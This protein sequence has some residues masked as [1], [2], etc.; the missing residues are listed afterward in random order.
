MTVKPKFYIT[1]PIYYVNA[2]PHLGH[3]YTSVAVDAMARHKRLSGY[4]V[5]FLT[6]VDEHGQKVETAA[7]EAGETPQAYV[8][9]ISVPF[10]EMTPALN[11]TNNDFIRTT[12]DRHQKTVQHLFNVL[13][14]K[15]YI[16]KGSYEGWYCVPDE[17]FFPETQLG[18][19]QTCPQCG[20]PVQKMEEETYFF[21]LSEF[22]DWFLKYVEEHPNTFL[23]EPRKNEVVQFVNQGLK[24]LSITRTSIHWGIPVPE[25]P[26]HVFYVWFDALINYLSAL[27]YGKDETLF[28]Q[29]WQDPQTEVIHVVGKEIFRF[30]SIIWFAML[31]A[32]GIR[33]PD[34]VVG[35][36]WWTVEGKKMSKSVG[37]VVNPF[38]VSKQYGAD[39]YRYFVLRELPFGTDGDYSEQALINRFD[40]DL[41]NDLGNLLY[42]TL[43]MLE[44]YNAG[45]IPDKPESGPELPLAEIIEKTKN[46]YNQLAFQQALINIWDPI[47]AA[48]KYIDQSAPWTHFKEGNSQRVG[49]ILYNVLETL[50]TVAVLLYPVMPSTSEKISYQLGIDDSITEKGYDSIQSWG[51]LP[52]GKPSR[53]GDPLFPRIQTK[54]DDP[55]GKK[56]K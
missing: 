8:D 45:V 41:A 53:K 10:R 7:Q 28:N 50:R 27:D 26:N 20:R 47:K 1:T 56:K 35:H 42:R 11:L 52:S 22:G 29:W 18:E 44:K 13:K 37:N 2:A 48:N 32:A 55:N 49:E 12:E 21:K 19:N 15:G 30:H 33:L 5:F 31:Q 25:A 14:E 6:G 24:D 34:R 38:E 51:L 17:T 3:S 36:G 43:N 16:Y 39:A 4:D 54:D 23:P 40:S 46:S 9:R